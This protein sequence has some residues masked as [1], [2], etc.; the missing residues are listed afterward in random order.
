MFKVPSLSVYV[1]ILPTFIT[2]DLIF[3]SKFELLANLKNRD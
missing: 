2:D 1:S 3:A